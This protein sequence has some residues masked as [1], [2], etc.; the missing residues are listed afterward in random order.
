MLTCNVNVKKQITE[1]KINIFLSD[2]QENPKQSRETLLF[3]NVFLLH[4]KAL[5]FCK[6]FNNTISPSWNK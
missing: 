2:L 5:L 3:V 1:H 4:F 6:L